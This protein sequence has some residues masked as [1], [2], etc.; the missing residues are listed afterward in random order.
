MPTLPAGLQELQAHPGPL[1]PVDL[2][3]PAHCGDSQMR[4]TA[5]GTWFHQGAPIT[6][7]GL[8]RLFST[9]LRKDADGYVLVTPAEKLSIAV[10]DA[11]FLAV[12][13]TVQGCGPAQQLVFTTNVGDIAVAGPGHELF[14]RNTD[15]APVPYIEVR[16]GLTARAAR[17]VYYQLADIAVTHQGQ[18]GVWSQGVFFA[19]GQS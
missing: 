8:V 12:L 6:R 14:F 16:R 19:F 18:T 2:W 11:P 15:G 4:I 3:H 5:D 7:A 9:V 1:P 10:D 13:L 17:P